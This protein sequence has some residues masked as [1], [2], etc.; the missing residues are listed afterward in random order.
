MTPQAG[1]GHCNTDSKG[2]RPERCWRRIAM[3]Y[4][5]AKKSM[6]VEDYYPYQVGSAFPPRK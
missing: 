2:Y 4:D 3:T 5:A 1:M 6:M